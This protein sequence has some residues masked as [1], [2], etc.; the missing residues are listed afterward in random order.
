MHKQAYIVCTRKYS[1]INTICI[2]MCAYLFT[3]NGLYHIPTFIVYSI[4]F[5]F[6]PLQ[7]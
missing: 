5:C 1:F 4:Y 2:Q 7:I 3:L 6:L